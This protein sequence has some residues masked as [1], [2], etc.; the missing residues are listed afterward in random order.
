M[1]QNQLI[2][3]FQSGRNGNSSNIH[4]FLKPVNLICLNNPGSEFSSYLEEAHALVFKEP[5]ILKKIEADLDHH[6]QNKKKMRI[7]DE[8]W[9][10]SQ[11]RQ[12]PNISIKESEISADDL[13]LQGGHPRMDA[14]LVYMFL[15]IRGF[16]GGVKTSLFKMFLQESKTMELLSSY[17]NF[18]KLPGLSTISENINAVSN[19]TRQYIFDAQIRVTMDEGF[20]DF[21]DLTIDSTSVSANSAWP[22]DSGIILGLV[23]RLFNRG[24]KLHKFGIADISDRRFPAIIKILK[25]LHKGISL[26]VRKP[27]SKSNRKTKYRKLL[28]ESIRAHKAFSE[29]LAKVKQSLIKVNIPPSQ[30]MK[31]EK[32]VFLLEADLLALNNV[33]GYCS[34]RI[35]KDESTPSNEKELSLSD[36]SVG[37]IKKGD[38]EPVIGYKP[39]LGRS[40]KG[41]ISAFKLPQGN[42]SDSAELKNI[43]MDGISHTR[44]IPD[45]ISADDGYSNK[46]IRKYFL[47][48]GVKVVSISGSKGK[49]IIG[50]EDWISEDYI[51]AR[52]NR[53]AVESLMFTIKYCFDFGRVM[54][55][56]IE[57]VRAELLEKVLAY[58]FCRIFELRRK[59]PLELAA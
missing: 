39:Q 14:Y 53:S 8:R 42:A 10:L 19:Q 17:V 28:K 24:K 45:I 1:K 43:V 11:S 6:G 54:R 13:R 46:E 16:L 22:T 58:N 4:T 59:Y 44:V 21:K 18:S 47:E 57:N 29:E 3:K 55:R 48:E 37:F 56:G 26:T 27:K 9:E 5:L 15:M 51:D 30:Y 31:L 35:N 40:K 36:K 49:K 2:K 7:L 12:L 34:K 50:E 25:Q 41:F 33:N 32:L 38:R 20:D 52:N 23:S